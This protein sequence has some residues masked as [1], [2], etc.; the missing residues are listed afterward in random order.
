[1]HRKQ[2]ESH[3]IY[4]ILVNKLKVVGPGKQGVSFGVGL[5]PLASSFAALG[6]NVLGTELPPDNPAAGEWNKTQQ[7]ASGKYAM[8]KQNIISRLEFDRLVDF[9]YVISNTST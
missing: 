3:E 2:W 1:M 6:S 7:H 8:F 4:D 5:E 9:K